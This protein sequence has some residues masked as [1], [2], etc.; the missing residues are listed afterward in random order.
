MRFLLW[1]LY[2]TL[3][4]YVSLCGTDFVS[5]TSFSWRTTWSY[6]RQTT[7]RGWWRKAMHPRS[8]D[9]HMT[10]RRRGKRRSGKEPDWRRA[11]NHKAESTIAS[12][13]TPAP[14]MYI[15]QASLSWRTHTA[16][17]NSHRE[18]SMAGKGSGSLKQISSL[19]KKFC[20]FLC[21][22]LTVAASDEFVTNSRS[23]FLK[24]KPI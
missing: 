14:H 13:L 4:S 20:P 5:A 23:K 16:V 7:R 3:C 2:K 1:C 9:P 10:E 6:A 15:N 8:A 11:C 19:K 21:L 12:C 18:T 22:W 17:Q 24:N